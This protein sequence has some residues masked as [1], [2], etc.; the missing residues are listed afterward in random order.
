MVGYWTFRDWVEPDGENVVLTW[1]NGLPK[2]AKAR[3]NALIPRL[4]ATQ[5]LGPPHVKPLKGPCAGLME[6]R[7]PC[8]GVEYRPLCC[9][10]P[11]RREVTIL[12]GATEVGGKLVPLSA[13]STAHKR[14]AR[15]TVEGLTRDHDFS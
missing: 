1:L 2:R 11:G 6:L 7:V 10:G 9:Y 15:L 8:E 12:V 3:I 5:H 14:K 13:C 4:E